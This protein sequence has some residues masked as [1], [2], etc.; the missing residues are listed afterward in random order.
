MKRGTLWLFIFVF[1][2]S[3]VGIAILGGAARRGASFEPYSTLRADE[4]GASLI[5]DT[6]LDPSVGF[7]CHRET[8]EL[9][10]LPDDGSLLILIHPYK[11]AEEDSPPPGS[12]RMFVRPTFSEGE[13]DKILDWVR[14]G[15]RLFVLECFPNPLYK[16]LGLE[17]GG[18]SDIADE[19]VETA[20]P[21]S[22]APATAKGGTLSLSCRAQLSSPNGD[23]VVLEEAA[24]GG[25]VLAT[26]AWGA[27]RVWAASDPS[28]VTNAGINH[29][30]H[31]ELVH[32]I[33]LDSPRGSRLVR[34]DELR[35][36]LR[37]DR[38]VMGYLREHG[39]HTAVLQAALAFVLLA[40]AASRPRRRL[41]GA[42]L[43]KGIESREFV[44]AMANI[45][46]RARVEKHAVQRYARR[47]ERAI[48]LAIGAAPAK[49]EPDE[50][51]HRL[52][53]LGVQNYRGWETVAA[54]AKELVASRSVGERRLVSFARLASQ[55]EREVRA[56]AHLSVD[57][58]LA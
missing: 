4:L 53:A 56:A 52:R 50:L 35:H 27:G 16:A 32:A 8:E 17:I 10:T 37:T 29:A 55:L 28:I 48:A 36:G 33:A 57:Q 58:V 49:L 13:I 21:V 9:V 2:A 34:F 42:G 6:L 14:K 20:R 12:P 46:E 31:V 11:A 1:L 30:G 26:S 40:W 23:W 45:Y 39:L 24:S 19:P 18:S 44:S 7:E 22:L 5:Y 43:E 38:N 41:R 47:C 51:A 54:E 15:G 3:A 25:A